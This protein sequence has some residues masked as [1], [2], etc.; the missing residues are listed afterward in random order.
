ME[1]GGALELNQR[2]LINSD[3]ASFMMRH[4][5]IT[6]E[7]MMVEYAHNL[8]GGES[9]ITKRSHSWQFQARKS[10]SAASHGVRMT[11]ILHLHDE[12]NI[13]DNMSNIWPMCDT[14]PDAVCL[15]SFIFPYFQA[16]RR[17]KH[18]LSHGVSHT[19][20]RFQ[21]CHSS[22]DYSETGLLIC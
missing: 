3:L 20:I 13:I 6:E 11:A 4:S 18:C 15:P 19:Q 14:P 21:L 17:G 8:M 12:K 9:K 16:A 10:F 22:P 2:W 5:E 1:L 7:V